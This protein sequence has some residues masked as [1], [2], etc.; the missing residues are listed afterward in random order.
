[1]HCI[2][3]ILVTGYNRKFEMDTVMCSMLMPR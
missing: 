2:D 1:M 3:I